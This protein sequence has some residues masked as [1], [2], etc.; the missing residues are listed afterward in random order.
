MTI[1]HNVYREL[2]ERLA[3]FEPPPFGKV[4]IEIDMGYIDGNLHKTQLAAYPM[5]TLKG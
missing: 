1:P 4:K 3:S 5:E 2:C